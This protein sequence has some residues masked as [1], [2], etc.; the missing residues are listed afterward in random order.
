MPPIPAVPPIPV[1]IPVPEPL[2]RSSID[3][4]DRDR[5]ER[6]GG[7]PRHHHH[8]H[9]GR[10]G[11]A[12]PS[13][14]PRQRSCVSPTCRSEPG[15]PVIVPPAAGELRIVGTPVSR[16][17]AVARAAE[18]AAAAAGLPVSG[19]VL[20]DLE[21]LA[22]VEK[23]TLRALL[24]E[25][26]AA[27]LELIA[28][29][30]FDLLQDPRRCIEEV[31]ISGMTLAPSHGLASGRTWTRR[32]FL[33]Q[34]AQVQYQVAVIRSF[35][36]LP[37][38]TNPA[39][40]TTGYDDVKKVALARLF[41]DDIVS[42]QVDWSLY[43][44]KAGPGRADRRR[45]R[46]RRRVGVGRGPGRP[47]PIAARRRSPEHSRRGLRSRGTQRPPRD[48]GA[49][50]RVRLGA[51]GYLNARPLTFGLDQSPRFD[52][53]YDVPSQCAELLHEGAIDL[54]HD[55]LD[56]VPAPARLPHRAGPRHCLSG[57]RGVRAALHIEADRARSDRSPWIPARAHPWRWSAC[58]ARRR[59]GIAPALE[60]LG[61]DLPAML[62]RCDAA[63]VIG[64]NALLARR[65]ANDVNGGIDAG[66][67]VGEEWTAM[68]G[69]PFVWAFW[70]GPAGAVRLRG[71]GRPSRMPGTWGSSGRGRL[72]R[73]YF[74][75][76]PARQDVGARYL[77]DNIR[78]HLARGRAA[79]PSSCSTG[80]PWRP[81]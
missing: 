59:F 16:A 1:P 54:G 9:A 21:R 49:M 17:A 46:S 11:A 39:A 37:R 60:P 36:P 29:A 15:Q 57:T 13:M 6:P 72:P 7:E 42:I 58:C 79:R 25:L 81:E 10:R 73:T 30:P 66:I 70:A 19:Y 34:V 47:A 26:C 64:D 43:G 28:E 48:S 69:L 52:L 80:T 8:W 31:N 22:A 61:P 76:A 44:P 2:V 23:I 14:A 67:D 35:A 12:R 4:R 50:S 55:P 40:P 53:R 41:L 78:Y 38:R 32:S 75:G 56:R 74:P 24:E 18:V 51:V 33:R 20:S 5:S 3:A 27:G 71:R 45:G 65:R 62:G 68:T 63:L 77:R